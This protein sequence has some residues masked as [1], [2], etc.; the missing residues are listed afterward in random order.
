M[1]GYYNRNV[2][3]YSESYTFSIEREL[4]RNTTLKASYIGT[5]AHHLLV[6][7][8]ANPGN[9]ALCASLSRPE[10]VM[11]GTATCG[12]FG[13][14]NTYYARD[15]GVIE[16]TRGPF[17]SSFAGFTYQKTIG[18]SNYNALEVSLRHANP[19][20]DF[21]IGYT[22]GKSLDQSSSLSEAINP[23]DAGL[24]KALSAF[25]LRHNFVASYHWKLPF[26]K[27]AHRRGRLTEGWSASGIVRFSTGL[28][29]TLFNNTD[30][31]LMGTI[32]NGINSDGIDTPDCMPGNLNVN[33]NP[34]NGKPA[35]NAALFSLPALGQTGTAARRFFYG[36]G[37]ANVDM[38]LHK[39][40]ALTEARSL[41][42]RFE[43]FNVFNHA[44]FFGAAA[45]N[46][47]ISSPSF[48]QI[49]SATDPRV[50]QLAAK[51]H[52]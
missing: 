28:P 51:L 47:N 30:T 6:I 37:M 21:L 29:V 52:F 45:V 16:G 43:A 49:V 46:G 36:P 40:V 22:Y 10:D 24:S 1:P 15:G 4:R 11:P 18:N 39:T 50:I 20:G 23:Y 27:L 44:Q 3:P 38:A 33:T 14:N 26:D 32:P 31:S 42:F 34:R 13:E 19:N 35:F 48:G 41:E 7:V 8:S 9:P 17:P 5:Q 2:T 12:P 25:D